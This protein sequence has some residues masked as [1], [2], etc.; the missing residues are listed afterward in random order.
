MTTPHWRNVLDRLFNNERM[1]SA[2]NE[3]QRGFLEDGPRMCPACSWR[4]YRPCRPAPSSVMRLNLV[5]ELVRRLAAITMLW[6]DAILAGET[7]DHAAPTH[8]RAALARYAQL[9]P[10]PGSPRSTAE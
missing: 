5:T 2:L 3:G 6:A 7:G 8:F 10:E 9:S 4:H 1:R